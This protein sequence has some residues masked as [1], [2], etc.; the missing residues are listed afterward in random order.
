MLL[1]GINHAF[2]KIPVGVHTIFA[3]V[4]ASLLATCISV[5]LRNINGTILPFEAPV[6][7]ILSFLFT[8]ILYGMIKFIPVKDERTGKTKR[9]AIGT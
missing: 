3:C 4:A 7:G 6:V 2:A 1:H 9:Y 8:D 5:S